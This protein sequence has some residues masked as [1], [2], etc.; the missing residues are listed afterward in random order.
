MPVVVSDWDGYRDS[1]RDDVDGFRIPT[2]M[3]GVRMVFMYTCKVDLV[4]TIFLILKL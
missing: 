3:P 1:V 4:L 2:M